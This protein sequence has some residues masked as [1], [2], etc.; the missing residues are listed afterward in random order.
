MTSIIVVSYN[1]LKY[2]RLCLESVR[3]HTGELPY[4][5]IVV[6]NGSQDGSAEWLSKQQDIICLLNHRNVGFPQACNQGMALSRGDDILLLNSD[7]V[8]TANYLQNLRSALYSSPSVG[9]VGPMASHA[10]NFQQV[11][12]DCSNLQQLQAFAREYNQS[13]PEKWRPWLLLIGF[14]LLFRRQVYEQLGGLDES[15]SPGNYEDDDYCLRMR[16]RGWDILLCGDTFIHHY[17]GQSFRKD[18]NKKQEQQKEADFKAL[19][20]RNEALFQKKYGLPQLSHK[21][22]HGM[23]EQLAPRLPRGS[24]VLLLDCRLGYDLFWLGRERPDLILSGMSSWE[25]SARLY[26]SNFSIY[27]QPDLQAAPSE[28]LA[29]GIEE[30]FDA[31]IWLDVLPEAQNYEREFLSLAAALLALGGCLYYTDGKQLYEIP[32]GA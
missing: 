3:K 14:C 26:L 32:Y 18:K 27:Y 19:V 15:F 2:T 9:A 31:V 4:E 6:D 8:V 28:G 16:Q 10:S 1:T 30:R 21:M 24:S 29:E 25:L 13:N 22:R 12:T 11:D 20:A 17:G 7:A 5:L 23:A